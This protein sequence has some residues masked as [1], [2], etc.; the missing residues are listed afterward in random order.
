MTVTDASDSKP[1][2]AAGPEGG[3]G[4][5]LSTE[6]R[7]VIQR[8]VLSA[9]TTGQIVGGAAM[10]SS[11][12]VGALVVTEQ[13]GATTAWAGISA[14]FVTTGTAFASQVLSRRMRKA[15][16]RPGLQ[17]GYSGALAGAVVAAVG[18]EAGMLPLFLLGLFI[19]GNGQASNLLARY[20]AADLAEPEAP[21]SGHQP[22]GVR[23][24]L[25]GGGR[26]AAPSCRRSASVSGWAGEVHRAV[27]VGRGI[28]RPGCAEHGAAVAARSAGAG[29]RGGGPVQPVKLPPGAPCDLAVIAAFTGPAW[30][31]W[32]WSISQA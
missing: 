10:A 29:R 5:A 8:R 26:T 11:V 14:A 2:T 18:V 23:P 27:A 15:G 1:A 17:I 3:P 25:R 22:G 31:C 30:L 21:Q 4:A 19:F 16:R 28:V 7:A 32:Q 9:L 12:T 24:D 6:E 20:A 13:L